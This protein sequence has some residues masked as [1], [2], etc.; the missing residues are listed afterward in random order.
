MHRF[1]EI[2]ELS[3]HVLE[4]LTEADW[5]AMVQVCQALWAPAVRLIWEAVPRLSILLRLFPEEHQIL[6][7]SPEWGYEEFV[8]LNGCLWDAEWQRFQLYSPFVKMLPVKVDDQTCKTLRRLHAY[9]KGRLLFPNLRATDMRIE[10][11]RWCTPLSEAEWAQICELMLSPN[12]E[13]IECCHPGWPRDA[14]DGMAIPFFNHLQGIAHLGKLSWSGGKISEAAEI[15]L[16]LFLSSNSSLHSVHL[17]VHNMPHTAL[18]SASHIP[19]LATVSFS[20]FQ[21]TEYV[22]S[23]P[24]LFASL[25]DLQCGGTAAGLETAIRIVKAPKLTRL[26]ISMSDQERQGPNPFDI[27]KDSERFPALTDLRLKDLQPSWAHL[28]AISSLKAL[29]TLHIEPAVKRLNWDPPYWPVKI[30]RLLATS[31]P[32]LE[33]LV[34]GR[35]HYPTDNTTVS[36]PDLECFAQLCPNLRHLEVSVDATGMERLSRSLVPHPSLEVVNLGDSEA[37]SYEIEIASIIF[38]LW[39]CLRRGCTS[40]EDMGGWSAYRW[41]KIWE[42]VARL[43]NV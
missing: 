7:R 10:L 6:Y 24:A 35:G 22:T 3:A 26:C 40:S 28:Q 8:A 1:W 9:S 16:S 14:A 43:Q 42:H 5:R 29:R 41:E 33:M 38:R 32:Q 37:D 21:D 15:S 2:P 19:T 36:L 11:S 18:L 17:D 12:L 23:S 31:F 25:T 27:L 4:Y 30:I 13:S 39:P 20:K 34:L